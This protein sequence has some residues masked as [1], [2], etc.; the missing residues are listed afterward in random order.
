MTAVWGFEEVE[1]ERRY[2]RYTVTR[3]GEKEIRL[4][5]VYDFVREL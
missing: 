5:L 3:K 1:G 4:R 2:V